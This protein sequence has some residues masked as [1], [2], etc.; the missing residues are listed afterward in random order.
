MLVFGPELEQALVNEI[1]RS[2]QLSDLNV[3]LFDCP[4]CLHNLRVAKDEAG[5]RIDCP[6][7]KQT[8]TVP[9]QS[10]DAGLFDDLFDS[11]P[12][13]IA[14]KDAS[15][16]A[17]HSSPL[18]NSSSDSSSELLLDPKT[19]P[20]SHGS[21]STGIL[22]SAEDEN[23]AVDLIEHEV[24]D[25]DPLADLVIPEPT[26]AIKENPEADKDPFE[27]DHDAP[28]KV[29]GVGDLFSSDDVFG[30]KCGVC[31]TRIHVR[32]KQI[33]SEVQ[34]PICFSQV[35]V[36]APSDQTS[37]NWEKRA[38]V[39]KPSD[40]SQDKSHIA[41]DDELKLSAPI[42][43]PKVEI[44]PAWGL[45][46]VEEDL[47]APKPKSVDQFAGDPKTKNDV[48]ELIV[49]DDGTATSQVVSPGQ[50]K[51][52]KWKGAAKKPA[53]STVA[54]P[55]RTRST[56][57]Q[58]DSGS[59]K[60]FPDSELP[61]VLSS[62]I[63]M[64]KSPG[65]LARVTVA[66]VLMCLG[67]IAMQWISPAYEVIAEDA[68]ASMLAR[69]AKSAKWSVA[70]AIYLLGLAVLWWT[71][72]YLFRDAALG[73][74]SVASW[75]NAGSNEILSTFLV[76][77]FGFFIGGLPMAFF[78]LLILPLR[79]LLGPLFL[80]SSW[81]NQSPFAIVSVDAFQ[82]ASKNAIQWMRFYMFAG[83]L[84]FLG[85][86][87]GIIFW[88]RELLPFAVGVPATVLGVAICTAATLLFAVVCG[89][90][91]GR[92]VESLETSE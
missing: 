62:A 51:P 53:E 8:L 41:S 21:N 63:G 3:I 65:V 48:P 34:C 69:L 58:F 26:N 39:K 56:R 37:L 28:L 79:F 82:S 25:S 75:S 4:R 90:H 18:G 20:N 91:C 13:S 16:E 83:G 5:N 46:P 52:A 64:I 49:V 2:A 40:S 7:C 12:A 35:K 60:D 23:P 6:Q 77:A 42:E 85:F 54:K 71:S 70:L 87:A 76:F 27:V 81:Y 31:D 9:S 38:G 88:M 86:V 50:A 32:K 89:W 43:L 15:R 72:S 55:E 19:N 68:E 84:A 45:A 57:S 11:A 17:T 36:T 33:G 1:I 10:A 44:D 78:S 24:D 80:L 14:G 74:R 67:A 66:F 59:G 30:T 22:D 73:K 92:V 47:L 61:E 29:D